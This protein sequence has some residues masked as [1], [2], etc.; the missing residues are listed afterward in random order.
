MQWSTAASPKTRRRILEDE[1]AIA[2][3]EDVVIDDEMLLTPVAS[4]ASRAVERGPEGFARGAGVSPEREGSP[5]GEREKTTRAR[6][7]SWGAS[8]PGASWFKS[9]TLEELE[10]ERRVKAEKKA[11]KA[12]ARAAAAEKSAAEKAAREALAARCAAEEDQLAR[13]VAESKAA[14][15]AHLP[16]RRSDA[17][18]AA[19]CVLITPPGARG[20]RN[21]VAAEL[22]EARRLDEVFEGARSE[23]ERDE[24]E[25]AED[26]A[27]AAAATSGRWLAVELR[28]APSREEKEKEKEKELKTDRAAEGAAEGAASEGAAEGAASEGAA[29][30]SSDAS[31]GADA[32]SAAADAS[33]PSSRIRAS[34]FFA[35]FDQRGAGGEGACTLCCV[36]TA[37]W[38]EANPGRMPTDALDA[39]PARRGAL[40]AAAKAGRAAGDRASAEA[41]AEAEKTS[42]ASD[43]SGNASGNASGKGNAHHRRSSSGGSFFGWMTGGSGGAKSA[44]DSK[45]PESSS[46][47][48][49]A[50][51]PPRGALRDA[52]PLS[53]PLLAE[54]ASSPSPT[55]ELDAILAGAA[56]EWRVLCR[57]E[58]LVARFPDKH[59][60]LETAVR[61]HRPF[62]AAAAAAAARAELD[63]ASRAAAEAEAAPRGGDGRRI[64]ARAAAEAAATAASEAADAALRP[65]R[66]AAEKKLVGVRVDHGESFVGFLVPPGIAPGDSPAVDALAAAAP[67]IS[68]I[69][70]KL[71]ASAPATY[72]VSWNDHFFVARFVRER[73]TRGE[74]E[75]EDDG[76]ETTDASASASAADSDVVAYV[77]DSLGERLSEGCKRGYVLRF[78]ASSSEGE[79]LGAA[80]SVARFVG[81]V[82]PSRLLRHVASDVLAHAEG[83][84][85]ARE[86][87]PEALMRKMQIEFHKIVRVEEAVV[88]GG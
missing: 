52:A 77:I 85:G 81:D 26:D 39:D 2:N 21:G 50:G 82:L 28:G 58:A 32:A 64:A 72:V 74:D 34:A 57:D 48:G 23:D 79:P 59:F 5:L 75:S 87:D 78:D 42:G 86:P 33:S 29:S 19:A 88:G 40:A 36:A 20:E 84:P 70:A 11:A 9:K 76:S 45:K 31:S 37:E 24:S 35:S 62:T 12:R 3:L 25:D 4:N 66:S 30:A 68:E 43:A 65:F 44:S 60:D 80:A 17:D 41:L 1:D 69:V 54:K 38:L 55:L 47:D 53:S 6:A 67:P 15:E 10:A 8:V 27:D 49:G 13:V 7:S 16:R 22:E 73:P 71:A 56:R 63:A 46:S 18:A 14:H 61:L 51:R 83:R